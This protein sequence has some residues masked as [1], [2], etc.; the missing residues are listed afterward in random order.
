MRC[1]FV[2]YGGLSCFVIAFFFYIIK[3]TA[4]DFYLWVVI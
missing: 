3:E 1:F 2:Y 4:Y